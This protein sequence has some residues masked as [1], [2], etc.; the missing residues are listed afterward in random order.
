VLVLG[1]AHECEPPAWVEGGVVDIA[2][3]EGHACDRNDVEA[4]VLPANRLAG[5]RI[6]Q[7]IAGP[8][9]LEPEPQSLA[10]QNSSVL[11]TAATTRSTE[12]MYASSI[13]QYGYGT[14]YPVTRITGARRSSIAFSARIAA[15]SAP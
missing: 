14:S 5:R 15:S 8:A 13:C 12:G 9:A 1:L 11:R 2:G 7:V 3:P 6:T 10:D 4:R